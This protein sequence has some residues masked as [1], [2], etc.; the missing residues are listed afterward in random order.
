MATNFV[1]MQEE[2]HTT[3]PYRHRSAPRTVQ[4]D[5]PLLFGVLESP[6]EKQLKQ[7]PIMTNNS[8]ILKAELARIKTFKHTHFSFA[9]LYVNTCLIWTC[10]VDMLTTTLP[11]R[12]AIC[13]IID[14]GRQL[15]VPILCLYVF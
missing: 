14:T 5:M 9:L 15:F 1:L 3:M 2:H 4:R 12:S 8:L 13:V 11:K 7:W 6:L 10:K